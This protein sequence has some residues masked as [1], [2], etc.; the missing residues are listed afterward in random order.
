MG[1]VDTLT[2]EKAR[3]QARTDAGVVAG[4]RDPLSDKDAAQAALSFSFVADRFLTEHA[5]ARLKPKT[6]RQYREVID[7]HMRPLLGPLPIGDVDSGH[8]LRVH[9][10]LRKTPRQANIVLAVLSSLLSWSVKAKYRPGPNPCFGLEKFPERRR[11]RYLTHAEYARLADAF[12][13]VSLQPG[14]KLAIQLLLL[15]GA[16]PA[17]IASLHGRTSI[18]PGPP[19]GCPRAR[20]GRRRS[21]C[22]TTRS[23]SSRNGRG[24][25]ARTSFRGPRKATAACAPRTCTPRRS[26]T[27]GGSCENPPASPTC[28]SLRCL[29]PFVRES[30]DLAARLDARASRR[31]ARAHA[32]GDDE[33]VPAHLHTDVARANANLVG[34]D[35]ATA[36]RLRR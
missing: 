34:G 3:R 27:P 20:P 25:R 17:E 32:A 15:T 8:A 4:G 18:S 23:G 26:H 13:S 21:I 28:V 24:G 33:S 14:P 16:R 11:E 1:R 9:G 31:A 29:S 19:C 36:L 12:R 10:R 22:P 30:G 7:D 5:E 2:L 35:I 6:L